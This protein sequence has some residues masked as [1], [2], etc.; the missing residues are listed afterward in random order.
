MHER[1]VDLAT[2]A[3]TAMRER[4]LEP[5]FPEPAAAQAERLRGPAAGHGVDDLRHLP[6]CSIDNDDSRDLDQLTVT[7]PDHDGRVRVLVAIAD[8]DALVPKGTPLDVHAR[9]NTTSVYTP[10]RV[11][12]ML[13]ERLSTDLTSLNQGEERVALVIS[14]GLDEE[15]APVE[16]LQVFGDLLRRLFAEKFCDERAE[17]SGGRFIS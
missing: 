17:F 1:A 10:A 14:F 2:L 12:P 9:R 3:E 5:E 13:P 6:W 11:F 15:D 4:G 8:V 7:A 16:G